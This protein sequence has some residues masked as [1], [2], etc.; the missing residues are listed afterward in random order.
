MLFFFYN[1]K[2]V[3][4]LIANRLAELRK[5]NGFT[6][7][8]VAEVL[9]MTPEGYS[10]YEVGKR[11]PNPDIINSLSNFYN[12]SSDYILSRTNDP[13]P[14]TQSRSPRTETDALN[15]LSE[16]ADLSPEGQAQLK[17]YLGLLKIKDMQD[18]NIE[19]SD[20]LALKDMNSK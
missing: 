2:V 7:K 3:I 15:E 1:R 10:Y 20:E 4:S 17:H 12:V 8:K 16:L 11:S 9:G 18:R 6:Q 13:T 14:H 5:V 19:I